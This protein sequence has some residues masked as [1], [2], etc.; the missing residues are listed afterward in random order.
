MRL[1]FL[2]R[3]TYLVW[4]FNAW[5]ALVFI[6]SR[7]RHQIHIKGKI[8]EDGPILKCSLYSYV[9]KMTLQWRKFWNKLVKG[10]RNTDNLLENALH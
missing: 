1:G 6:L 5:Q 8:L 2:N 4:I 9:L 10:K 7:F 3:Y